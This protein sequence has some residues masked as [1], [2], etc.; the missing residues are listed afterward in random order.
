MN[1]DS[2]YFYQLVRDYLTVYLPLQKAAS[3]H[4][5]KAYRDTINLFLDY[6]KSEQQISLQKVRFENITRNNVEMFLDWLEKEKKY[7]VCPD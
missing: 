7:S 5:I 3:S 2:L 6:I 4:T 1:K